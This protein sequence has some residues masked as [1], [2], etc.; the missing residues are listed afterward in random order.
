[1]KKIFSAKDMYDA[2]AF[3]QKLCTR[4]LKRKNSCRYGYNCHFAHS[5][6]EI[7]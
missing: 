4:E 5:F 1:M 6:D 3:K 2:L 7:L